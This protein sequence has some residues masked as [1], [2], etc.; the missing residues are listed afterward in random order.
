ME[1]IVLRHLSGSK[2]NQVEEFPLAHFREL[3]AGRDPSVTVKYDP[4]R[5]DLV[6]RQHAK[7]AQD[8][9]DPTQ[10][11]L[12]DL[13]SRNG[14]YLN[15]QR[16]VGTA[17]IVPGDVVQFGAGGPEFQFDI[18][19]RPAN[20]LRP[21]RT[22]V[23]GSMP[24]HAGPPATRVGGVGGPPPSGIPVTSA[25]SGHPGSGQVGKATVE[26]MISQTKSDSRKWMV[27]G[28]GALVVVILIVAA[29]AGYLIYRSR[30]ELSSS[31]SD[32]DRKRADAEEANRRNA[33]LTAGA[34]VEKYKN[35][36]VYID[37]S[38]KLVNTQTGRQVY[39]LYV[40]NRW[41]DKDGTE[42]RIIN[43]GRAE[44]ATYIVLNDGTYEPALNDSGTHAIGGGGGGSGFTVTSDGFILTARHVGAGWKTR[45]Q[46]PSDAY[47]GVLW[48]TGTDGRWTLRTNPETGMPVTYQ[49]PESWVPSETRQFGRDGIRYPVEGKHE[50][51]NVTFPGN[52][53]SIPAK[54]ARISDRHDVTMLK[55]DVPEAVPKVELNDNYDTIKAG[56]IITVLGYP[57]VSP[58]VYGIVTSQDVFNRESQVKMVP[59]PSV[60][61]GNIGRVLR[62]EEGSKDSI[63]SAFGDA[64]QVTANPGAG[65]SGGP[66]FDD[67]G[68]VIGIYYA[69]KA[70]G[71]GTAGQVSFAVPIRFAKELMR[72]TPQ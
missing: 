16:I 52:K 45:Y 21:T 40:P 69:G 54:I 44:V 67:R 47:P 36:V 63:T 55:I 19:P 59:D 33:P 28:G 6:G 22:A 46:Y 23:D 50:Y 1:R 24:A 48:V 42:R 11:T 32:A 64:Y 57:A 14:T 2:A 37:V 10:F 66:V 30:T 29:A 26:R 43:D 8:P 35:A 27:I 15:K 13:N 5:D 71:G 34:I 56:D 12:T 4:D 68:G 20:S 17:R 70:L 18:E 38:W 61:V 58:I 53:T 25:Q 49:I 72:T 9:G 39:H 3:V 31:L 7:I 51:I 41:R 60:T 62:G 65:N